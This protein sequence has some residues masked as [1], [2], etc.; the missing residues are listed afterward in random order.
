MV[1]TPQEIRRWQSMRGVP[2]GW[3]PDR[4]LM[5]TIEPLSSRIINAWR[6]L[7]GR[8]D[9]LDWGDPTKGQNNG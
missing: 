8:Y 9:A 4:G 5:H 1:Y 2:Q 7:T 6:V 3:I